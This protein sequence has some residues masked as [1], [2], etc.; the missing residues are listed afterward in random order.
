MKKKNLDP[1]SIYYYFEKMRKE[2]K[3]QVKLYFLRE[4]VLKKPIE[5]L[6]FIIVLVEFIRGLLHHSS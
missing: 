6:T 3:K 1:N 4:Y 2:R 5:L